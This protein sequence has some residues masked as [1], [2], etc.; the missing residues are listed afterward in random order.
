MSED[1]SMTD[2]E[3]LEDRRI[4]LRESIDYFRSHNK[5]ERE[6]WVCSEFIA[7]LGLEFEESEIVSP[8]EDPPDITFRDAAFEIKEILDPGRKRHAEYKD[9][10]QFALNATDPQDLLEDYS[11]I[12]ITPIQIGELLITELESLKNRYS[13]AVLKNLDL[14]FYINLQDHLL[15]KGPMPSIEKFDSFGWR[16]VSALFGWG[17]FVFYASNV[18][19]QFLKSRE[20]TQTLRQFN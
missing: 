20:T 11:P 6:C 4:A 7:N 8:K 1:E 16:S 18:S 15:I 5:A 14:L 10:L 13:Q 3:F 2:E 9:A 19:P 17:S 12:E